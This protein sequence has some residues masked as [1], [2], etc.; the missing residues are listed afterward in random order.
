M[1]S[2]LLWA[3]ARLR[4]APGAVATAVIFGV[5]G[6]GS[7]VGL[8][9]ASAWLIARAAQQPS[10]GVLG[11]SVIAVRALG[12]SRGVFRYLERLRSHD[13]ALRSLAYLRADLFGQISRAPLAVVTTLRSGTWLARIGKDVDVVGDTVIKGFL[14]AAVA[15]VLS[16][17]SVVG[18]AVISL[19]AA[20]WLAL[21]LAV[22]GLVAPWL[23]AR[24]ARLALAV[25]DQHEGAL[26][27]TVHDLVEHRAEYE[28]AGRLPT[29][30][31]A[32]EHAQ[33]QIDLSMRRAA[34]LRGVADGVVVLGIAVA[35]V[36][37]AVAGLAT[38]PQMTNPV[39]YSVVVLFTLASL[40]VT[41]TLP[42]A[43]QE[44]VKGGLAAGRLRRAAVTQRPEVDATAQAATQVVDQAQQVPAEG[45]ALAAVSWPDVVVGWP[46]SRQIQLPA[47]TV[48]PGEVAVISGP[49]GTGKTTTLL[50][51]AGLLAPIRGQVS[52]HF[53]PSVVA[54]HEVADERARTVV[55]AGFEDSHLFATTIQQNLHLVAGPVNDEL[56]W[57]ALAAVELADWV[58][59]LPG[60]LAEELRVG[61]ANLAGGERRRLVVARTLVSAAPV[62][63]LDEPT[64]HLDPDTAARVWAK[65]RAWAQTQQRLLVVASHDPVVLADADHRIQLAALDPAPRR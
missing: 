17:I 8:I 55:A 4:L 18:V 23:S 60:G 50:T 54:A 22:A 14:P 10:I 15:I 33:A 64:E 13:V 45:S 53:D 12:V 52:W 31:A 7:A 6:A 28:V 51:I 44:V 36:G 39:W 5:L 40:D 16:G 3:V 26:I 32:V 20:L 21:G 59:H 63:L 27:A 62:L 56:L 19:P 43:A 29:H 30:L 35:V 37:A 61:G 9:A 58:Q 48:S 24:G 38:V 57:E 49:S 11:L 42:Q 34:I 2:D 25:Q 41:A 47:A 46:G 1:K 65:V